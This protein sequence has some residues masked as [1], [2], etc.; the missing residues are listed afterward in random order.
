LKTDYL[1][2]GLLHRWDAVSEQVGKTLGRC[3]LI[4]GPCFKWPFRSKKTLMIQ[5]C[6]QPTPL[7]INYVIS[8][9]MLSYF[10]VV[11][12]EHIMSSSSVDLAEV[13]TQ[14]TY[15]NMI[16]AVS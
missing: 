15:R 6:S 13:D 4:Q 11:C 7:F 3:W 9:L 14:Q 16:P 8:S 10:A 2:E 1:M 12:R 5:T